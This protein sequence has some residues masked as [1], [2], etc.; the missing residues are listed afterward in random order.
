M[1]AYI[2]SLEG[3][4]LMGKSE[5][6]HWVPIDTISKFGGNE[7]AAKPMELVLLGLGSCTAMDVISIVKK[8]HIK[9]DDFKIDIEAE[10]ATEHPKVF[11]Q[12]TINYRFYGK[13][14]DRSKL[15]KAVN[16]SQD[17]YCSVSAMLAKTAD[18][19]YKIYINDKPE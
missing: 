9:L 2:K 18:I 1:K 19:D 12:I 13:D 14:L 11:T 6:G 15:E 17:K 10:N 4:T 3:L 8:M 7:G 5:S 16:L